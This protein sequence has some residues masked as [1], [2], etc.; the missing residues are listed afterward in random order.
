MKFEEYK[1]LP[2]ADQIALL[3]LAEESGTNKWDQSYRQ[4]K[5]DWTSILELMKTHLYGELNEMAQEQ[6]AIKDAK[7]RAIK[8]KGW[9]D[10]FTNLQSLYPDRYRIFFGTVYTVLKKSEDGSTMEELYEFMKE[11][12]WARFNDAFAKRLKEF[13]TYEKY[14]RVNEKIYYGNRYMT[15]GSAY[16]NNW[17]NAFN[18]ANE[19]S[20]KK[21][22]SDTYLC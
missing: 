3:K 17:Y 19:W 6:E 10:L 15:T 2:Y 18:N 9:E 5:G 20:L 21:I 14:S 11:N 13:Y 8:E 16:Y 7:A 12:H 1:K 4:Y 22:I